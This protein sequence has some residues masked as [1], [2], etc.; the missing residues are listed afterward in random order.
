MGRRPT[1]AL[2]AVGV[3]VI[4]LVGACGGGT[5]E[6]PVA[7]GSARSGV[8]PAAREVCSAMVR[9]SV[10]ASVGLPL[11]REP[12]SSVRGDVFS[13]RYSFEGGALDLSVRDL[14]TLREARGRRGCTLRACRGWLHEIRRFRRRD[15]G[16]DDPDRRRHRPAECRDRAGQRRDRRGGHRLALLVAGRRTT[17]APH[18]RELCRAVGRL[19]TVQRTEGVP[20]SCTADVRSADWFSVRWSGSVW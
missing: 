3:S 1:L 14:H 13:C 5:R 7:H 11:A 12:V 9:E 2:V 19:M 6:E 10:P 20:G 15:E 4:A 17:P 8:G 16:R 18:T